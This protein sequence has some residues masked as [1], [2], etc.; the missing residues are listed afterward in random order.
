M[1]A[2]GL[3]DV[4][5]RCK[6]EI[7]QFSDGVKSCGV[8]SAL[9]KN[10]D[11]GRDFLYKWEKTLNIRYLNKIIILFYLLCLLP[12]LRRFITL[13]RVATLENSRSRHFRVL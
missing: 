8:L 11:L 7:D 6:A 13:I 9:R 2:L 5:L 3:H 4:I 1:Q 10:I 12:F